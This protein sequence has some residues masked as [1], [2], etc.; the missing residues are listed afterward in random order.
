MAEF[1]EVEREIVAWLL[2]E[3]PVPGIA[4]KMGRSDREIEQRIRVLYSKLGIANR[5][6]LRAVPSHLIYGQAD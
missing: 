1:S 2:D 4:Q 6:E 3:L 5:K